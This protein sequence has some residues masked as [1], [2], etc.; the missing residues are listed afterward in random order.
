MHSIT[1]LSKIRYVDN[2]TQNSNKYI[3]I[4]THTKHYI[5]DHVSTYLL[6][7]CIS[8]SSY[9]QWETSEKTPREKCQATRRHSSAPEGQSWLG[10]CPIHFCI[11]RAWIP[12]VPFFV[13]KRKLK[14][15]IHTDHYIKISNGRITRG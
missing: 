9:F 12:W 2:T 3:H 14:N 15:G 5:Y 11:S 10:K 8:K 4:F 13:L 1:Y 7:T 6:H